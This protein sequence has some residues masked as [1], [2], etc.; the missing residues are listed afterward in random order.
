MK[1]YKYF[2]EASAHFLTEELTFEEFDKILKD[3]EILPICEDYE[4]WDVDYLEKHIK[5]IAETIEGAV[6]DGVIQIIESADHLPDYS[7]GAVSSIICL[8]LFDTLRE[9][10]PKSVI[11]TH[12]L[13]Q[14]IALEFEDKHSHI[15]DG[16]WE[17][18]CENIGVNDWE[19]YIILYVNKNYIKW[20]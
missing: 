7:V 5:D 13:I 14:N 15:L 8:N 12:Y 10:N 3:G 20:I 9:N 1:K 6:L 4:G 2:K 16:D 19:E 18:Y 17:D 11:E